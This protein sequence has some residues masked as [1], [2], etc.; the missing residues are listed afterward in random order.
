MVYTGAVGRRYRTTS[1]KENMLRWIGYT[2]NAVCGTELFKKNI[3]IIA[4]MTRK[5]IVS[6]REKCCYED[7]FSVVAKI[8]QVMVRLL[9]RYRCGIYTRH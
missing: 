2:T 5:K 9:N 8:S 7:K 6:V 1:R 4:E 3:T